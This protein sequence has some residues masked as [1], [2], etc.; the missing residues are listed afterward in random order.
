MPALAGTVNAKVNEAAPMSGN[1]VDG[2]SVALP[3]SQG[4]LAD[5][6]EITR[7][8]I[9]NLSK[10]MPWKASEIEIRSIAGMKELSLSSDQS[11]L[12][13]SASPILSGRKRIMA[14]FDIVQ[15]SRTVRSLWITADVSVRAAVLTASRR[16]PAG[17]TL[18]SDDVGVT[19]TEIPDLRAHYARS[20]ED[21]AGMLSRRVFSP[22]D[23]LTRE[24]FLE[25]FLVR[26]GDIVR[27]RLERNGIV[28][29]S[30]GRAEQD[31]RLGQIIAVRNLNF[32]TIVKA[33][34]TGRLEVRL[35]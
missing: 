7:L 23:P 17:K 32:S 31:G 10:S 20:P 22:G 2:A 34:V 5:P 11:E 16:I 26:H 35:E 21:L 27:L 18:V 3:A 15:G 6:N 4:T 28:V 1:P 8:L 33:Q 12:R 25:P 13:L 30:A 9:S 19:V 24:A 29:T 14:P